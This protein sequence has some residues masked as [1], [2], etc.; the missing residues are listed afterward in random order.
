MYYCNDASWEFMHCGM[1]E[2]YFIFVDLMLV[3][4]QEHVGLFSRALMVPV[5]LSS[6]KMK[7]MF[8]SLFGVRSFGF[9]FP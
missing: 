2:G 5:A 8:E 9:V 4:A 7:G 3:T 1:N 6:K